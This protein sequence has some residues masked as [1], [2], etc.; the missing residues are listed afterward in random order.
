MFVCVCVQVHESIV[1]ETDEGIVVLATRQ[2]LNGEFRE[3]IQQDKS[4][5]K[6]R[7]LGSPVMDIRQKIHPKRLLHPLRRIFSYVVLLPTGINE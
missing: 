3:E 4:R 2:V 6:E 7:F 5:K 1:N